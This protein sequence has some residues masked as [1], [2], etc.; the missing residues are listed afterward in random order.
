M[1]NSLRREIISRVAKILFINE[2]NF[3]SVFNLVGLEIWGL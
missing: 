3:P 1:Q 2:V